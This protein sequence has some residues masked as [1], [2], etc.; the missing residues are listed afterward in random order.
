MSYDMKIFQGLSCKLNVFISFR[1]ERMI[2]G[3][4]ERQVYVTLLHTFA[5]FI[6]QKYYHISRKIFSGN[7]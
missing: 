6:K 3:N 4:P 5:N 1:N 2:L 7:Q